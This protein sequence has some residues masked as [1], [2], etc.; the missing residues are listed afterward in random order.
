MR[1]AVLTSIPSVVYK[2]D[3]FNES[4][5]LILGLWLNLMFLLVDCALSI[6]NN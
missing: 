6:L 4:V 3:Y 1:K 2:E 5:Y